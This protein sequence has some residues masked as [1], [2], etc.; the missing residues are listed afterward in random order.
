[1][2][3]QLG[4]L[5]R[6]DGNQLRLENNNNIV[7]FIRPFSL[8]WSFLNLFSGNLARTTRRDAHVCDN[9]CVTVGAAPNRYDE[10]FLSQIE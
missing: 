1:M 5:R 8:F 9:G 4:K 3:V 10:T 7:D 6:V 2:K